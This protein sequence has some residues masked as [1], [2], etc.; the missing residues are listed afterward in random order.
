MRFAGWRG[1]KTLRA[2]QPIERYLSSV[3]PFGSKVMRA[4]GKQ[5]DDWNRYAKDKQEH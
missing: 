4:H 2:A 5:K 1:A 3:R